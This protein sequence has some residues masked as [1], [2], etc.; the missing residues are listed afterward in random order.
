VGGGASQLKAWGTATRIQTGTENGISCQVAFD[1]LGNGTAVWA[2]FDG[3][4]D[5]IWASRFTT[6][7]WGTS[8]V[9]IDTDAGNAQRP[10]I[11]IN[12]SGTALVV[13]PQFDGTRNN[14]WANRYTAGTGWGTAALIETNNGT[15]LFSSVAIDANGNGLAVW[16]Q[17]DGTRNSIWSNRYTAGTGWG[18][19]A[20]IET[21]DL[22]NASDAQV[23]LDANGNGLAVWQ[24]SD[25]TRNNIWSNR[26]TA[27]SGWGTATL[28]ESGAGRADLPQLAIEPGGNAVAVWAQVE[29]TG[30]ASIFAN[31]YMVGSGWETPILLENDMR[32]AGRPQIAVNANGDAVAVWQQS[33]GTSGSSVWANRFSP[34]TGWGAATPIESVTA[35]TAQSPQVAIDANGNALAVWEH[36]DVFALKIWS[37]RFSVGSGW[38]TAARLE[39]LA[40]NARNAQVALD[41]NGN[42]LAVWEQSTGTGSG[43]TY[44]VWASR[45]Q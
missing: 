11:A 37:N 7:G 23:A 27:G 28:I 16:Q 19:A 34:G 44:N 41:A 30:R 1:A 8:A 2:Q 18:T 40:T 6:A 42:G 38:G 36:F 21:E 13:W 31:R 9:R 24:Q 5:S 4:R 26:Y 43:M 29:A 15:A 20:L 25:G 3:T 35:G 45:F 22:G 39:R 32:S 17:S 14:I 10:Q 12:A 33:S